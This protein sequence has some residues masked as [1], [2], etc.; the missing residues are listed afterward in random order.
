M[1]TN[2]PDNLVFLDI[3]TTGL[4]PFSGAKIVEIAMLKIKDGIEEQYETLVNP[5]CPVPPECSK[6]HSIYD[7]M[8]KDAPLFS[9]IAKDVALFIGSS[10][11]V[12]HNAKFDLSFVCKELKDSGINLTSLP[13]IDTLFLARNHFS[14]D[15]NRLGDIA[16]AVGVEVE[17]SHRA[18]ADVLTMISVAKYMFANMHRKGIDLINPKIFIQ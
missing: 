15:S 16:V 9:D 1:L 2:K 6:I 3:E 8:L 13:Y 5:E 14:F 18:M 4:N 10:T 12:C 7:D 11:L 17:V